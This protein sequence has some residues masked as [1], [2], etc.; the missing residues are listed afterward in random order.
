MD[1]LQ[2]TYIPNWMDTISKGVDIGAKFAALP[3]E[4]QENIAQMHMAQ[5]ASE[6]AKAVQNQIKAIQADKTKSPEDKTAAIYRATM[7]SGLSYGPQGGTLNT[8]SYPQF[9]YQ[10]HP[11]WANY[12]PAGVDPNLLPLT[13]PKIVPPAPIGVQPQTPQNPQNPQINVAPIVP[14]QQGSG[15]IIGGSGGQE[16]SYIDPTTGVRML[17]PIGQQQ[18]TQLTGGFQPAPLYA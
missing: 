4:G 18:Q 1:V 13:T 6:E 3:R 12:P 11:D 16:V 17:A 9:I 14:K 8:L 5:I 15:I 7:P 10:L 2:H